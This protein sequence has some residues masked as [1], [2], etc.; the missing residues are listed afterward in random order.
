MKRKVLVTGVTGN[1]GGSVAR[2]L[3]KDGH[4]VIG[5]TRNILSDKAKELVGLG[6]SL[7]LV[8]FSDEDWEKG[9]ARQ[10]PGGE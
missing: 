5:I 6:A 4:E 2:T 3:L 10:N 1:Q 9:P 8:D 7:E